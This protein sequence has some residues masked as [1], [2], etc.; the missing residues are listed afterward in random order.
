M[1]AA[2]AFARPV[3]FDAVHV[4]G[5]RHISPLDIHYADELGYKI[6]L[7]GQAKRHAGGGSQ[8]VRPQL[9]PKSLPVANIDGVLNAVVMRGSF[10][11]EVLLVGRGAGGGP[12]ASAVAADLIDI[13]RGIAPPI[14]G[15]TTGHMQAESPANDTVPE[16][17]QAYYLRVSVKDEPGV[18]ADIA[19]TLRDHAIS[20]E[21]V[22]QRGHEPGQNVPVILTTHPSSET[23]MR[24][25][26]A[27]I[28]AMDT[29]L[30]PTQLLPIMPA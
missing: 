27:T 21:T 4:D 30:A 6:K 13:A 11:D 2:I 25:A 3:D 24:S 28:D 23:A 19:A 18:F 16:S 17:K 26:L 9:I 7:L 14:F 12:T 10:V 1:L 20:L 15:I 22:V 8:T 5:I 29:V